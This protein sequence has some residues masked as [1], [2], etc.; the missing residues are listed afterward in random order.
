MLDTDHVSNMTGDQL[1]WLENNL[2]ED[3]GLLN[4]FAVYHVPM[5]PSIRDYNEEPQS[6]TGRSKW[7]P[8]FEKYQ[9]DIAFEHHDHALKRTHL[10]AKN[11][12]APQG[13]LYLGDGCWGKDARELGNG[14]RWYLAYAESIQHFW[15][16]EI[17]N[18]HIVMKAYDEKGFVHD[19]AEINN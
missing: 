13:V 7:A 19:N 11:R 4:K 15:Y 16:G 6:E 9:L 18:G 3:Q 12:V 10:L 14:N 1:D 5:Y 17:S 8:L 2:A